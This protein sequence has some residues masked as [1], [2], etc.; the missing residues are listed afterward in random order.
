MT[1]STS[2]RWWRLPLA[3][4]V[5]VIAGSATFL[6]TRGT[7]PPS[8][9]SSTRPPARSGRRSTASSSLRGANSAIRVESISP[10]NGETS[11]GATSPISIEFSSPI[12]GRSPVPSLGPSVPGAWRIAGKELT[13]TPTQPFVPLSHVTLT[14]PGG[15][16]GILGQGGE[17]R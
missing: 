1:A 7:S 17:T 10:R 15:T 4:V 14:I 3:V 9:I 11:V 8:A 13:F 16:N 12:S 2:L 5:L 6:M